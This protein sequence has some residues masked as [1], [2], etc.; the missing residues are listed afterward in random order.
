METEIIQ[1][2]ERGPF[3][4]ET[5]LDCVV[6]SQTHSQVNFVQAKFISGWLEK[7]RYK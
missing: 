4:M 5:Y 3:M 2:V 7:E 6:M 1:I